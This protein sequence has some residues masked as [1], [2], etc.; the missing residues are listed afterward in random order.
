[1]EISKYFTEDKKD[2][3]IKFFNQPFEPIR[4]S[5]KVQDL[6]GTLYEN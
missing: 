6:G 3:K 5:Y 1:M 4:S 2:V